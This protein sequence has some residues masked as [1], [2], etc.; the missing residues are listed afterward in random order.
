M[1]KKMTAASRLRAVLTPGAPRMTRA[2]LAKTL[3]V[4][5]QAVSAWL[6][7]ISKPSYEL[8]VQIRKMFGIPAASWDEP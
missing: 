6:M 7:K 3:G 4:S 8:R 1:K 2:E 5:P